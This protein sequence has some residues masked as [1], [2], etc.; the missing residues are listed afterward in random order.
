MDQIA[1]KIK[2][3]DRV[4]PM[5]INSSEEQ[6]VR[7][8]SKLINEKINTYRKKYNIHDSQDLLAMVAFELCMSKKKNEETIII[9]QKK[10]TKQLAELTELI[11]NC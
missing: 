7:E 11:P 9:N 5:R 1:V 8:V 3:N 10:Y 4:Y 2:I 6:I